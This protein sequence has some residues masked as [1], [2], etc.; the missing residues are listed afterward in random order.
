MTNREK[1]NGLSNEKFMEAVRRITKYP[2][3]EYVNW[4]GWLE[5]N[6]ERP[7]YIGVPG[8]YQKE[9]SDVS[10]WGKH[11]PDG[12]LSDSEPI[13]CI[14][15]KPFYFSSGKR[16]Y[17]IAVGDD[18]FP[19]NEFHVKY[20]SQKDEANAIWPEPPAFPKVNDP[21][22]FGEEVW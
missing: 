3:F 13:D 5:S 19:V 7:Q 2:G 21:D 18:V 12:E 4:A 8:K 6:Q 1:I 17:Y 16:G 10:N 22:E 11:I 15:L 9:V 20:I 14:I